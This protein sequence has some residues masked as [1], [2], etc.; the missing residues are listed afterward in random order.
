M[1]SSA[2]V[3]VEDELLSCRTIPSQSEHLS[4]TVSHQIEGM[5]G[6]G[7]RMHPMKGMSGAKNEGVDEYKTQVVRR[8]MSEVQFENRGKAPEDDNGRKGEGMMDK[9]EIGDRNNNDY[10]NEFVNNYNANSFPFNESQQ[11][12]IYY[13]SDFINEGMKATKGGERAFEIREY[14]ETLNKQMTG[15]LD[16]VYSYVY[17]CIH[18]SICV[19]THVYMNVCKY[20][21]VCVCI[22]LFICSC[23]ATYPHLCMYWYMYRY[24]HV[25]V[26]RL[27]P[28]QLHR[29]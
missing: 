26:N 15:I 19:C 17:I 8:S 6:W 13:N 11:P 16:K 5:D 12:R 20:V 18:I 21:S 24:V 23:I 14:M 1:R 10:K 2:F 27:D 9:Y 29:M 7:L 3:V 28:I 25:L 4:S 22:R